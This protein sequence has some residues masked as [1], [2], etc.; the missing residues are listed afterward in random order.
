MISNP[1]FFTNQ[2]P[3]YRQYGL[4]KKYLEKYRELEKKGEW[5]PIVA[6]KTSYRLDDSSA[7]VTAIR[8]RLYLLGDLPATD[9]IGAIFDQLLE[10]GVRNF[11][12]RYGLKEDGV[13]GEWMLRELNTLSALALNRSS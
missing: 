3:V 9:T 6:D 13:V 8:K 2:D 10:A 12:H 5:S 4:L 7:A 11:Q 1:Q